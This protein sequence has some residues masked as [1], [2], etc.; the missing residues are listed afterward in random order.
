[1]NGEQKLYKKYPLRDFELN[2]NPRKKRN[3]ND[4]RIIPH[5]SSL[6]EACEQGYCQKGYKVKIEEEVKKEEEVSEE[7][8]KQE[9]VKNEVKKE[10][11]K[12]EEE[13]VKLENDTEREIRNR[14]NLR[15]SDYSYF[16]Y[17]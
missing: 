12:K 13:K 7:D 4:K 17:D 2:G 14:R 10:D 3:S 16:R 8:V 15:N 9:D 1:M 6:C 5:I 11:V